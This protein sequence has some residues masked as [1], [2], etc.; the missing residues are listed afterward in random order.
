MLRAV[1]VAVVKH[2]DHFAEDTED[3][4]WLSHVGRHDWVVLTKDKRIRRREDEREALIAANV[5][6]FVLSV[7]HTLR[8]EEMAQVFINNISRMERTIRKQTPPFIAGV[9]QDQIRMLYP[10]PPC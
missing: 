4:D 5:R 6:M 9:Y 1:G 3:V 10:L 7:G 2:D 8:G